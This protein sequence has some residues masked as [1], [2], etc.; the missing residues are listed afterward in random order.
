[1]CFVILGVA[2]YH[3]AEYQRFSKIRHR[4]AVFFC[5]NYLRIKY[6]KIFKN[7]FQILKPKEVQKNKMS[8]LIFW[9]VVTLKTGETCKIN[10]CYQNQNHKINTVF[11][12]H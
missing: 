11:S 7:K 4:I 9:G 2:K 12:F 6:L 10:L 8:N 5:L 3:T 1:M